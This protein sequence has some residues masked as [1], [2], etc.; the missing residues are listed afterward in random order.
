MIHHR[1]VA[2][3]Y[4][5]AQG[6][7]GGMFL[8]WRITDQDGMVD[9]ADLASLEEQAQSPVGCGSAG[10]DHDPAC[11]FVQPVNGPHASILGFQQLHQA[12]LRWS[13]STGNGAKTGRLVD[14]EKIGGL[15]YDQ[16][17]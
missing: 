4:I 9:L 1:A 12:L 15:V 5:E 8:P 14:D 11:S 16:T 13:P 2:V 17:I 7:A 3:P 10:K 6:V